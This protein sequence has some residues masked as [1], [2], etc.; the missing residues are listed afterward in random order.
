MKSTF[1]ILCAL[2]FIT[3]LLITLIIG[4]VLISPLLLIGY[5]L[6]LKNKKSRPQVKEVQKTAPD[7]VKLAMQHFFN[8]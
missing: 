3:A 5:I 2:P 1:L 7:P 8:K 4:G 6:W